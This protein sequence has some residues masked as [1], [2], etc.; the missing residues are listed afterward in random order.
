MQK[1]RITPDISIDEF[2]PTFA[3]LGADVAFLVITPTG[4]RNLLWMLL[5]LLGNY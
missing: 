2:F 1:T 3:E 4:T 5:N